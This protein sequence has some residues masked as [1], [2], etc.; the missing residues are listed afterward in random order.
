MWCV[1]HVKDRGK[2]NAENFIASFLPQNLYARCFH[3][4]RV[5]RK[6]YEGQWRTVYEDLLPGYIFIDTDQPDRVYKELK[7]ASGPKLLFSSDEY[8]AAME[9]YESNLMEKL[10]DNNGI[11][12]M[13]AV[14]RIDNGRVEYLSGPLLDIGDRVK[15]IN[16][17][18]RIAEIETNLMGRK[19]TLYLGIEIED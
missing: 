8:V 19:Q 9:Q 2:Q 13:S 5:R 3:L 15:K 16:F 18:K 11:I 10:A 14:R 17:H 6:K 4:T 1:V 7:R 12:G